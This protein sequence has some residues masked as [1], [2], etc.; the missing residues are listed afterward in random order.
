MWTDRPRDREWAGKRKRV[1]LAYKVWEF[2]SGEKN[3][4]LFINFFPCCSDFDFYLTEKV[5]GTKTGQWDN[6]VRN[7]MSWPSSD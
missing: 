4:L 5:C 2:L 6:H 7:L 3:D 1:D